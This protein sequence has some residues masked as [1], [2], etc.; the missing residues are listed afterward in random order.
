MLENGANGVAF[1]S[2]WRSALPFL[3]DTVLYW[4]LSA[5][6]NW[7]LMRGTGLPSTFGH[8]A[9]ALGFMGLGTLLPAGPG[10]FGAY[11]VA[12]YTA[13]AMYY[14]MHDVTTYG[15]LFVFISYVAHV[16]L[17]ALSCLLGVTLLSSRFGADGH[18]LRASS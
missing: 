17:N 8:A 2:S 11:Q 15:A 6:A 4:G 5:T 13:L 14:P 3:M 10:F 12:T 16:G 1:L 9:V 7:L 18:R